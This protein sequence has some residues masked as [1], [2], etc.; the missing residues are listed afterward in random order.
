LGFCVRSSVNAFVFL[1]NEMTA[2]PTVGTSEAL[3]R[4][5]VNFRSRLNAPIAPLADAVTAPA[6]EYTALM[7]PALSLPAGLRPSASDEKPP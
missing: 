3:P 6:D 4:F 1:L 2:P 5:E 7:G